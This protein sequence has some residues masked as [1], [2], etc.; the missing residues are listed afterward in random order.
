MEARFLRAR[1]PGCPARRRASIS[2]GDIQVARDS[3]DEEKRK[4]ENARRRERYKND[5][6]YREKEKAL[7]HERYMNNEA[8]RE[9]KKAREKDRWANDHAYRENQ[10]ANR[11]E[12]YANDSE[13]R[14]K[15]KS[16]ERAYRLKREYGI[17]VEDFG[18]LLERQNHRCGVCERPFHGMPHVD[19]CHI[20]GWVRGLLCRSCNTGLGNL[21]D[22]PAFA[23]KAGAYLERWLMHLLE[24][25]NIEEESDMTSNDD[26][27]EESNAER[28]IRK[29]IVHELQ[30]PFGVEPPPASDWL[31]ALARALIVKAGQS[32][33]QALKE[34]F[35]RAGG[36]T[37]SALA[38]SAPRQL[39]LSWKHPPPVSKPAKTDRAR[40]PARSTGD[41]NTSSA[42]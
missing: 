40:N 17:S 25:C 28:M 22:N 7:Q 41:T 18:E 21:K 27:A 23:Y 31:Q 32:D 30:Q 26:A 11:R 16:N 12:R 37:S 3:T 9:A 35:D 1:N 20:T 39:T 6:V 34:V 38:T 33:V 8:F 13:Y 29:A 10:Q 19:H 36:R 42:S 2:S 5:A 15:R 4:R 24:V 14:A